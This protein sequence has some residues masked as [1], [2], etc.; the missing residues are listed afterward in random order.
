M[1]L[2]L[3]VVLEF[4][5]YPLSAFIPKFLHHI[6]IKTEL[7][8]YGIFASLKAFS[9]LTLMRSNRIFKSTKEVT[10]FSL[11]VKRQVRYTFVSLLRL[12]IRVSLM[13]RAM[14][15]IDTKVEVGQ[16]N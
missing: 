4:T 10:N 6:N 14:G 1:Q 13:V 3:L 7:Q 12:S 15:R 16:F 2:G 5:P 8:Y 9:E 11:V